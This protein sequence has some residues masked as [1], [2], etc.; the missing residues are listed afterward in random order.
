MTI[1]L[2][3]TLDDFWTA[4]KNITFPGAIRY[5]GTELGIIR[6]FPGI[7]LNKNYDPT[8][9]PWYVTMVTFNYTQS[10]VLSLTFWY[11][12][13]C[14]KIVT[15]VDCDK[16]CRYS[17]ALNMPNATTASAPYLDAFG[18]GIVIT[19]SQVVFENK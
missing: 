14:D 2:L 11:Y 5:I 1:T 19:I 9:R 7:E 3:T 13:C 6:L 18:A 12:I 8:V 16:L 4:Q 17:R 10:A 15:L